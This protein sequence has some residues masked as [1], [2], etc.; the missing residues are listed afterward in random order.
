MYTRIL[1]F[2]HYDKVHCHVIR[3]RDLFSAASSKWLRPVSVNQVLMHQKS[4]NYSF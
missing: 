2:C 4:Y 1:A 3:P